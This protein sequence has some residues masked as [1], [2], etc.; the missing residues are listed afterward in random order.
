MLVELAAMTDLPLYRV[1]EYTGRRQRAHR[2]FAE[3][4]NRG[5]GLCGYW[6]VRGLWWD[7]YH[8]GRVS[9]KPWA[10]PQEPGHD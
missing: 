2:T 10:P 9:R 1:C 4:P 3:R 8:S 6:A 5:A 7:W